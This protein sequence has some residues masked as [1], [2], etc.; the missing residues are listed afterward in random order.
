MFSL[1]RTLRTSRPL[2][3]SIARPFSTTIRTQKDYSVD[4]KEAKGVKSTTSINDKSSPK[5]DNNDEYSAQASRG[6][7]AKENYKAGDKEN[8][9]TRGDPGK[10]TKKAE[11][12]FPEAPKPIIG[13]KEERGKV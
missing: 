9:D 4:E 12:E 1:A 11:E 7:Q 13:M 2:T 10:M 5:S 6:K 3:A 8:A